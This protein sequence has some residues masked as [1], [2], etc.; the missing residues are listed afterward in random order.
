MVGIILRIPDDVSDKQVVEFIHDHT[1]GRWGN[2]DAVAEGERLDNC[3]PAAAG[4]GVRFN[5]SRYYLVRISRRYMGNW[6]VGEY[7]DNSGNLVT[8]VMAHQEDYET[9]TETLTLESGESVDVENQVP[10]EPYLI[11][12]ETYTDEDG[13][14]RESEIRLGWYIGVL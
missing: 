6:P 12:T 14:E 7:R 4:G 5:G 2:V 13:I 3:I 8:E 1:N 10:A 11:G 9:V